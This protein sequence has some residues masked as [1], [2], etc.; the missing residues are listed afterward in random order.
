VFSTAFFWKA[1]HPPDPQSDQVYAPA[2]LCHH[3]RVRTKERA[4]LVP[5]VPQQFCDSQPL[6]ACQGCGGSEENKK[7]DIKVEEAAPAGEAAAEGEAPADGE[8]APAEEAG[9]EEEAAPEA[10]PASAE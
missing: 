1:H 2:D 5:I 8:A 10:D 4:H 9:A 7:E 6:L 3:G